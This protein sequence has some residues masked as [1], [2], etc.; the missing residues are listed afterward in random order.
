MQQNTITFIYDGE[1]PMCTFG[2]H[3]FRVKQSVGNIE[4]VDA[5]AKPPHPFIAKITKRG[6]DLDD[7]MVIVYQDKFYHGRDALHLMALIGSDIGWFNKVNATL[8]KS[9]PVAHFLYPAMR[10][11]RNLLIRIK[12]VSAIDNLGN[13]SKPIFQNIFG[14]SWAS[15]PPV[16]KKHYANRP[17]SND[18]VTVEGMMKVESSLFARLLTPLF[19]MAGSL[20]PY[21][22][23][24]IPVT[25]HFKSSPENNRYQFDRTFNFPAKKP[26]HFRSA[27]KPIGGNQVVEFMRFGIGWRAAYTWDG[28]DVILAHKGYVLNLFGLLLPLPLELLMGKG[29]ASETPINDDE[30]SMQMEIRHALFGKIYEYG[31]TFKV[32][33]LP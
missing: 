11:F 27:M 2:S 10:A 20:V 31:G 17:Y 7:G 26:Y 32:V 28:N 29:N 33:K 15:L 16:M 24:N 22:G 8:F 6:L 23:E 25:V 5:R 1:C 13:A 14:D 30:F 12:G 3:A 4:L 9:E 18:V 21:E 19:I